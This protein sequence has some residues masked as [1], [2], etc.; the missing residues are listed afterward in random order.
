MT[1]PSVYRATA[2]TV[3]LLISGLMGGCLVVFSTSKGIEDCQ[4]SA[5]SYALPKHFLD[6]LVNKID[7]KDSEPARYELTLRPNIAGAAGD[8]IDRK[9]DV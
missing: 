2:V 3:L 7:D 9:S 6:I 1:R 4:Q 5:G 8:A